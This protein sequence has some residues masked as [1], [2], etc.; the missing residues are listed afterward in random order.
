MIDIITEIKK[1]ELELA[2]YKSFARGSELNKEDAV[3]DL[4]AIFEHQLSCEQV[5]HC[6]NDPES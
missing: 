5:S 1:R 4:T 3:K 6:Q 2:F